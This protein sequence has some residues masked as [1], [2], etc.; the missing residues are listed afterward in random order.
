MLANFFSLDGRNY[1]NN[2]VVI[3]DALKVISDIYGNVNN[4]KIQ[5]RKP[6][7]SQGEFRISTEKLEGHIIGQF[8]KN[9]ILFYFSYVPTD[10]V[11]ENRSASSEDIKKD[12]TPFNVCYHITDVCRGAIEKGFE[13]V[14]GPMSGRDKVIFVMFE[15]PDTAVFNDIIET[16]IIPA[17]LITPAVQNGDRRFKVSVYIGDKLLGYRHS[18]VKE[19]VI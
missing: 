7:L 8:S 9:N 17:I 5:F 15:I 3:A 13:K 10:I 12:V 2:A 14:Y 6:F 1:L 11:L 19:F 4:F 18:T 16:G